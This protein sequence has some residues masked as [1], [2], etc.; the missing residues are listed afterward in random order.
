MHESE[1]FRFPDFATH[2]PRLESNEECQYVYFS[3][4]TQV[5][6][7]SVLRSYG[8]NDGGFTHF[9]AQCI[10]DSRPSHS[11]IKLLGLCTDSECRYSSSYLLSRG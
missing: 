10:A 8:C 1:H 11:A 7:Y 6:H 5:L 4:F 9:I 2:V 3:E